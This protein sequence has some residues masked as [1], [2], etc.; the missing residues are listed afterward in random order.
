MS[1]THAEKLREAGIRK[2]G[3]EEAWRQAQ[4]EYGAQADRSTPRGFEL[5]SEEKKSEI[6]KK[7]A[8]A[9]WKSKVRKGTEDA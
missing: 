5:M 4:R 7:G 6:S 1:K 9:R 2:Y 3:S 8:A